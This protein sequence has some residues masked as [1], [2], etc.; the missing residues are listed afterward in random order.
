VLCWSAWAGQI[1]SRPVWE[2]VHALS[3]KKDIFFY[4]VDSVNEQ[5]NKKNKERK[6]KTQAPFKM[7][8]LAI[9]T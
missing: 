2:S 4:K 1:P 8:W 6:N 7:R 3:L 9:N 5:S